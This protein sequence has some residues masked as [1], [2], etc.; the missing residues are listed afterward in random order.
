MK[1]D[2]IKA[3]TSILH[4]L[5]GAQRNVKVNDDLRWSEFVFEFS[6]LAAKL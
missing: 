4:S 5:N 3:T 6:Q 2:Y 1:V